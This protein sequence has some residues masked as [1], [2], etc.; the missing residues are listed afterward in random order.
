M[1]TDN[2]GIADYVGYDYNND[3][4]IDAVSSVAK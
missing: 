3:G 2:D 4:T 1:D